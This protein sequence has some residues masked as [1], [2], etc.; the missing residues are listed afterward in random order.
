MATYSVVHK[1][2]ALPKVIGHEYYEERDQRLT[3]LVP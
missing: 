1:R 2:E 3:E